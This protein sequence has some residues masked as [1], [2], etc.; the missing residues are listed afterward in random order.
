[1]DAM[2]PSTA[3]KLHMALLLAEWLHLGRNTLAT[4]S[5]TRT[6]LAAQLVLVKVLEKL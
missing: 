5:V 6:E 3:R 1:M 2:A 4:L